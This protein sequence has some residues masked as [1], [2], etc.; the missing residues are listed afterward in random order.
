MILLWV[1]GTEPA[2][3]KGEGTDALKE[4]DLTAMSRPGSPCSTLRY[5]SL[6]PHAHSQHCNT[7]FMSG[8]GQVLDQRG[9]GWWL[10][11]LSSPL[12][13]A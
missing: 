11:A 9:T 2:L 8:N 4:K 6:S 12:S 5:L 10:P 3:T 7:N 1:A 13:G